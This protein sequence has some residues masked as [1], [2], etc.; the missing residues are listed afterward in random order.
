[1]IPPS[2][3]GD[4]FKLDNYLESITINS[5]N[6]FDL[7]YGYA[8]NDIIKLNDKNIIFTSVSN[9]Y[10]KMII[11]LIKLLNEDKNVLIN[12]YNIILN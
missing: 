3:S 2:L 8:N 1:M 7:G 6:E 10:E 11:I 12:Y 9:N 4:D 5:K